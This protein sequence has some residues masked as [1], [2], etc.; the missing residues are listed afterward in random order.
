[1]G[2]R[3]RGSGARIAAGAA[4]VFLVADDANVEVATVARGLCGLCGD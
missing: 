1:M 3:S 4:A 2:S